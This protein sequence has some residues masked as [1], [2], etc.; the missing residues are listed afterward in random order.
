MNPAEKCLQCLIK[1]DWT[2][3]NELLSNN[4]V[5]QELNNNPLFSIFELN[6]VQELKRIEESTN[7]SQ[8]KVAV[9]LFNLNESKSSKLNLR[10]ETVTDIS[11]YLFES[12]PQVEYARK[13]PNSKAAKQFLLDYEIRCKHESDTSFINSRLMVKIGKETKQTIAK[14]IFNSQQEIDM[15]LAAKE[16]FTEYLIVP[17]IA[18]STF[19][20]QDC[21]VEHDSKLKEYYFKSVL[22]LCIV[23]PETFIPEYCFELD[24][25][26]HDTENAKRKDK[27]KDMI[28][29]EAGIPLNRLRKV[30]NEDSSEA[31]KLYF[32]KL[33][34]S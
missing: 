24:S 25:S 12:D 21:L 6:L 7:E 1:K 14:S 26:F 29:K 23:N 8:Y 30:D 9:L 3:L 20:N 13:L 18:I 19:I 31:F 33:N 16:V 10:H 32:E 27:M 5:V 11:E 22:D 28:F 15:Y 34:A 4:N 17:N 2:E